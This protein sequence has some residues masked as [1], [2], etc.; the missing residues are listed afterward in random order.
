[1][2][3]RNTLEVPMLEK[4]KYGT[5]VSVCEDKWCHCWKTICLVLCRVERKGSYSSGLGKPYV[6]GGSECNG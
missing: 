2:R 6:L 3:V 4:K 1:M 5:R